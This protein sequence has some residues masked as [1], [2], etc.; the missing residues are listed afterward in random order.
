MA[1]VILGRIVEVAS[2]HPL[3]AEDEHAEIEDIEADKEIQPA[4]PGIT[5]AVHPARDLRE[6]VMQARQDGKSRTP[7]HDVVK[8]TD[9]EIG[10]VQVQVRRQ[11]ADDKARKAADGEEENEGERKEQ[12]RQER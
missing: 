1:R 9:D 2:R 12:R 3:V 10:A 11:R 7:E 8:V 5:L 4:Y 6:P